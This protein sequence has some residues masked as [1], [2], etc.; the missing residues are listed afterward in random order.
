MKDI[1]AADLPEE[2]GLLDGTFIWPV[3]PTLPSFFSSPRGRLAL[4]WQQIK[5]HLSN[6][7]GL[8]AY[9][10]A[11]P[12]HQRP[13][14]R[15]RQVSTAAA[16]LHK[17]VYAAFADNDKTSFRPLT[18]IT[19]YNIFC[20]RLASRPQGQV[21]EWTLHSYTKPLRKV[22]DRAARLPIEGVFIRQAVV[23]VWTTQSMKRW[24]AKGK[25]IPGTDGVRDVKEWV[26]LQK[27]LIVG[28]ESPWVIWGILGPDQ[29]NSDGSVKQR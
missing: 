29:I 5:F 6:I 2:L 13:R 17:N 16:T 4:H 3:G 21:C 20:S 25:L 22:S 8:Y 26:V 15:L 10:F 14:L 9:R 27:R 7:L 12:K 18:T 19:L 23:R 24:D 1:N 11:P 28:K